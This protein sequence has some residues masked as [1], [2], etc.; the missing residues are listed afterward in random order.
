MNLKET[1][2]GLLSRLLRPGICARVLASVLCAPLRIMAPRRGVALRNLEIALPDAS[3]AERRRILRGTYDH[4]VWTGIEFIMLQRDPRQALEWVEPENA[5]LLDSLDGRGAILLTGHVGNW[6]LV[7]AWLAQRGHTV[8]AI[9]QETDDHNLIERMRSRVGLA[10]ISKK[11][12]MTRAAAILRRGEF[13]GILP[14]QH[15]GHEG[16]PA[17]FFGLTTSTSQGAAVFAYLTKKPLVPIFSHRISPCRHSVR[18]G[19]PIEWDMK[20][21]REAT[22]LA[23][24]ERINGVVE[25]MVLEAPDQWLAQHRRFKEHY[26]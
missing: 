22:I 8:T 15:G 18:I 17:K 20:E 26:A 23:I 14:D 19:D 4:L 6:E 13:L 10:C 3:D 9:V 12:P 21:N 24:T 2:T 5:S 16:I 7:A 1:A 11:A 25:R